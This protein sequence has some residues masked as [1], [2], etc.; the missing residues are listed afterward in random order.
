MSHQNPNGCPA[1]ADTQVAEALQALQADICQQLFAEETG[2]AQFLADEWS[3][4]NG[5]GGGVACVLERGEVFEKAGVNYSCITGSTLPG[6]ASQRHPDLAGQPFQAM[7]VSVVIHPRNPYVPTTHAN[8]RFFLAKSPKRGPVWWFGGGFDLTPYYGFLEDCQHWHQVAARTC[9]PFGEHVYPEYK[10]FC[11]RYFYLPHRQEARGIG[12]VFFDDLT[13]WGFERC[14]AF[15]KALGQ[16]FYQAYCPIVARRK[17]MPYGARE[18]DFQTYRRGRY[19]EF[20]LLYDRGTTF[21]LQSG[22]R[23]ESILMSLPPV[24][25]WRYNWQPAPGSPEATLTQDFLKPRD[26]LT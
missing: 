13:E 26:W 10:A 23:T 19:V 6:T 25:Q 2:T 21:G 24:T 3:Y 17:S 9:R 22:G 11:D 20:N 8:F 15:I 1:D 18:R 12:G 14:F 4:D 5:T 16:A 7:G